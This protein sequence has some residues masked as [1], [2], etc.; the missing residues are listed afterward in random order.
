MD[1]DGDG[2]DDACEP[3]PDG[4]QTNADCFTHDLFC[5]KAVGACHSAGVCQT[6]PELCPLVFAPVCGCNGFTYGNS[7]EAAAQGVSV[8]KLGACNT[9]DPADPSF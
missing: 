9:T 2:C 1:T 8:A 6:R 3:S 4:C 5:A 7:C